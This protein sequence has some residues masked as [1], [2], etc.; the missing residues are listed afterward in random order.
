VY[1]KDLPCS[2]AVFYAPCSNIICILSSYLT[3]TTRSV[4]KAITLKA[5]SHIAYRAHA[6]P[7][8]CRAAKGLERVFPVWFTQCGLV[9]FTLAMPCHAPT[10]P[11]SSR[12]RHST[13]VE[14]RPMG[15]LPAFGFFRLPRGVPRRLL[16]EAYQ[17]QIQV[18]SVKPNNVYHGRGKEW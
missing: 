4:G 5:D 12:T 2:F 14:R 7:Q 1:Y 8:P 9:W 11:F 17:S 3:Q 18:A 13:S 6:I 15:Y 16:S 10:M